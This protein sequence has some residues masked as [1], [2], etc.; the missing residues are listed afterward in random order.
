MSKYEEP[1][2]SQWS[3]DLC[4][5]LHTLKERRFVVNKEK[6]RDLG[7]YKDSTGLE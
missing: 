2:P 6:S 7:V 5:T 4:K 3:E 1:L